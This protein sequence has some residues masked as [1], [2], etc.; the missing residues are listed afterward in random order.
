MVNPLKCIWAVQEK[1]M[2]DTGDLLEFWAH[3]QLAREYYGSTDIISHKQ[4]DEI[5]WWS[6]RTT[7]LRLPHLFQLWA[8]KH[9]NGIAG[10]MSFLLHQ[11][12]Q[13]NLCP[14]CK[15]VTETCKHIAR[16]P[17]TGRTAAFSQSTSNLEVWLGSNNTHPDMQALILEYTRGCGQV[18][19]HKCAVLLELPPIMHELARSQDIIGWDLF[20]MGMLSTHMADVQSAYLL[21]HCSARPASKWTSGL[22]TQLLQ[23][24]HLQWN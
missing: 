17:E 13:C 5:D 18:T 6:L 20:M 9:L 22:I 8:S 10:T 2:S 19:C 3:Q 12:G 24:T 23:I 15:I 21:Q 16:C 1:L 4:F 11:D 7:L 14:S